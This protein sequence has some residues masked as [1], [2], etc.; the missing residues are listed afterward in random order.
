[1]LLQTLPQ[2]PQLLGSVCSLVQEVPHRFGVVVPQPVVFATHVPAEH[3]W[4][5]VHFVPQAPQFAES[6]WKFVQN[7]T[8]PLVQV[9]GVVPTQ[10]APQM[11]PVQT[12]PLAQVWPQL[13]QFLT[14]L[15]GS[16]QN[17]EQLVFGP[18]QAAPQLPALQTGLAPLQAVEQVPQFA[19]S[20]WRSAHFAAAPVPHVPNG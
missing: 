8:V 14:S 17:P 11:P 1:M 15:R 19:G 13:P 10:V 7:E 20:F 6:V 16:T 2:E 3:T 9:L 5:E 4:L 18:W 12:W